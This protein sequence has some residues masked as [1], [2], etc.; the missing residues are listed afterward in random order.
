MTFWTAMDAAGD[1]AAYV[2][3]TQAELDAALA[4]GLRLQRD[5][6]VDRC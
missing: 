4:A 6:F 5:G 3:P 1:I 2:P